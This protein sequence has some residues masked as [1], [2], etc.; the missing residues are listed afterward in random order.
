MAGI[1]GMDRTIFV[2]GAGFSKSVSSATPTM[3]NLSAALLGED[4]SEYPFL[5][6][7]LAGY[8][9]AVGNASQYATVEQISTALFGTELF[10]SLTAEHF[11]EGARLELLRWISFKIQG[12]PRP[13]HHDRAAILE[14]LLR[15]ASVQ[16]GDRFDGPGTRIIS[17]NYDLLLESIIDR[18]NDASPA[19]RNWIYDYHIQL[20][21]YQAEY[22]R[23]S[24]VRRTLV[25]PYLKLHGSLNWFR[26]AGAD[27]NDVTSVRQV[28][29]GSVLEKVHQA[30]PPV[31][32]PMAHTR[33]AFL[34][35]TL[36][37][38]L[39]RTMSYYLERA[40]NIVFIGYGFPDT[41][42]TL[43]LE[44]ARYKAKV[45]RIVIC[46]NDDVFD[47]KCVRLRGLFPM[48]PIVNEDAV[49]WVR[50]NMPEGSPA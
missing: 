47:R 12:T 46:E 18:A 33:R 48:S 41:D 24:D 28:A 39:W 3:E 34:G 9:D 21:R 40:D 27:R 22:A 20:A 2:L 17:L 44:F 25:F 30:D 5:R 29:P 35:G 23:E 45:R 15:S 50:D 31:F 6:R 38:T 10:E 8:M 36:F 11:V 7:Y 26:A 14:R 1:N 13:I 49:E 32:V 42:L 43:L 16:F 19:G 37:P 4:I